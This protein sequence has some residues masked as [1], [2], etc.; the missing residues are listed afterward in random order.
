MKKPLWAFFDQ[1]R[2]GT[3]LLLSVDQYHYFLQAF[4]QLPAGHF[5]HYHELRDFC[6][7]FWLKDHAYEADF[8]LVFERFVNWEEMRT[9]ARPV[10]ND[11]APAADGVPPP[12][13][14]T[15]PPPPTPPP[16]PTPPPPTP[17]PIPSP[18]PT[19]PPP[20]PLASQ[21]DQGKK[22]EEPDPIKANDEDRKEKDEEAQPLTEEDA[23]VDFELVI[24]EQE[25]MGENAQAAVYKFESTFLLNDQAI[26]PFELRHFAQRLRRKVETPVR[27]LTDELDFERMAE[28]YS[29]LRYIDQVIYRVKD[30]SR[31]NVVLL[32]D[33]FGSMLAYEY[34]EDQL[35]LAIKAIPDCTFE[36]YYFCNLPDQDVMNHCL[37]QNAG[38]GKPTFHTGKHKWDKNTWFFVF[39]DAG[40]LSGMVVRERIG[41]TLKMWN[42]FKGISPNVYWLNPV[43][44]TIQKGTTAQRLKMVIPMTYPNRDELAKFF[45]R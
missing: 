33:R 26:M 42:Y 16:T 14:P 5:S 6:K 39:S 35:T 15:S 32:A 27:E 30:S 45:Q 1:L 17:T 22:T 41:A 11:N 3:P 18:P 25:G 23:F 21:T 40:A 29:K 19:T 43:H 34:L 10:R 12:T 9:L 44:T 7:I 13:P 2:N 31:S 28:Q 24:S 37:L 4:Q 38:R 8:D 20:P 36:H